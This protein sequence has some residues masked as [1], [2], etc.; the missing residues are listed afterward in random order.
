[1][2]G[3][4]IGRDFESGLSSFTVYSSVLFDFFTVSMHSCIICTIKKRKRMKG[5][6]IEA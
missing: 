2:E 6:K 5:R 4:E 1:M 3:S